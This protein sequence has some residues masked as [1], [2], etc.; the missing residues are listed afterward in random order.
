MDKYVQEDYRGFIPLVYISH[1]GRGYIFKY[2]NHGFGT[3]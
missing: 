3:P 2:D 1:M